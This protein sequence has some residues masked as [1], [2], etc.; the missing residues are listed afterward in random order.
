M[1]AVH[2]AARMASRR[3]GSS[4]RATSTGRPAAH[5][6]PPRA[7]AKPQIAMRLRFPHHRGELAQRGFVSDG[8]HAL[9]V[10]LPA[11]GPSAFDSSEGSSRPAAA[12]GPTDAPPT[13]PG[14]S[15]MGRNVLIS[16]ADGRLRLARG[17]P[18]KPSPTSLERSGRPFGLNLLK[19]R[20]TLAVGPRA[21]GC[22]SPGASSEANVV[23]E[24][25]PC[26][27]SCFI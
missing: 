24:D 12:L 26:K 19:L 16:G 1:N 8:D 23:V 15:S 20:P 4:R 21:P 18:P 9:A 14:A 10:P 27:E 5:G 25:L 2:A 6:P 7:V 11:V 3:S 13:R 17:E 22:H